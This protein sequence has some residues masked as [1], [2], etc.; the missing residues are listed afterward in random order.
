MI[1]L[2]NVK[3]RAY[4]YVASFNINAEDTAESIENAILDK[5]GQNG[6]LLKDSDRAYSKSKCWITYEEVVDGS[7][8]KPLQEEKVVRT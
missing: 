7:S 1:K 5:I 8:T 2:F 4:G 3:I 6:V